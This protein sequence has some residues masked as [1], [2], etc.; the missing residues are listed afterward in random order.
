MKNIC[1]IAEFLM[2]VHAVPNKSLYDLMNEMTS[3]LGRREEP[4]DTRVRID[5]RKGVAFEYT[6]L[7]V[8]ELTKVSL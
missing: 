8:I 6:R 7:T 2:N 1:E 3:P 5:Q 4:Y